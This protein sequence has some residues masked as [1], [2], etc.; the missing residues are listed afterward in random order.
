MKF[1]KY[2]LSTLLLCFLAISTN[3]QDLLES[4]QPETVEH[5]LYGW[6]SALVGDWAMVGAPQKDI[7][8]YQSAGSVLFYQKTNNE[9]NIVL[10]ASP[11]G[12]TDFANF[13]ASVSFGYDDALIGAT[14]DHEGGIHSGAIYAYEYN[15]TTWIQTQKL[16]ASDT[17]AGSRFGVS[18]D[19][20]GSIAVVGA[21]QATGTEIKSGAAYLFE[22]VDGSW[23]QTYKLM[24]E[25]GSSHDSFGHSVVM[26]TES[27]IAIGAYNADGATERTGV[28]YIF[29]KEGEEWI[30]NAKL[31]DVAGASSDLFGYSVTASQVYVQK[32]SSL[33]YFG[34]FLYIGAPGTIN[35]NG[36]TGSVYLYQKTSEDSWELNEELIEASSEHNDHFGISVAANDFGG[37]YVGASRSSQ[38]TVSKTGTVYQYS[39]WP[40]FEETPDSEANIISITESGEFDNFGYQVAADELT[41]LVSSPH[42]DVDDATNSGSVYFFDYRFVSN[43]ETPGEEIIEYRLEQNYPNPFNPTTTINYQVKDAGMVR[44]TV[45]NL[46]GQAVQVLVNEQ[47]TSGTYTATFN[48]SSLASGFYFYTL[49]VNDFTSTKK[50]MLIK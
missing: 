35:E 45:F 24:A 36:K 29:E 26:V 49:E 7:G 42:A 6:S 15:D 27:I 50:M 34:G 41:L 20:H 12:L 16:K 13:G 14:G 9:W 22:K 10:E 17:K 2:I 8:N 5:A 1:L 48:A 46:L 40:F 19:I 44:L 18:V 28:V 31:F 23:Q 39:I 37:F 32:S 47:Q 25:D 33:Q 38:S 4:E 3:A 43:E 30:Q 21:S 11:L